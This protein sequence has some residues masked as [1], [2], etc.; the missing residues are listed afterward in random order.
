[1]ERPLCWHED[2]TRGGWSG[3]PPGAA[4]GPGGAINPADIEARVTRQADVKRPWLGG[5]RSGWEIDYAE[6][7]EAK[8][9]M[10]A[11][12]FMPKPGPSPGELAKLRGGRGAG[13][14][15]TSRLGCPTRAAT[16]GHRSDGG[17]P[18]ATQRWEVPVSGRTFRS[19]SSRLPLEALREVDDLLWPE[20]QAV[21]SYQKR[22]AE[23]VAG[24]R[25][26]NAASHG[27]DP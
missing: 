9:A 12:W 22:N 5:S 16:S 17:R 18:P 11:V 14:C 6:P 20:H 7:D 27:G 26:K 10:D 21:T 15:R 25:C 23:R 4:P 24:E 3:L 19:A 2:R 8:E 13:S 1:M